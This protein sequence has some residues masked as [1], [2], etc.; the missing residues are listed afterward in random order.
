[1]DAASAEEALAVVARLLCKL[2]VQLQLQAKQ[3]VEQQQ[4]EAQ[5]LLRL[6]P[7]SLKPLAQPACAHPGVLLPLRDL[8]G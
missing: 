1:V 3:T 2:Q 7:Q 4:Q 8:E 6:H 5:K